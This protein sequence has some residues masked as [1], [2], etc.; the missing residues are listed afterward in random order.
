MTK[1]A[2]VTLLSEKAKIAASNKLNGAAKRREIW[3]RIYKADPQLLQKKEA[4][5]DKRVD[6]AR[7]AR[8]NAVPRKNKKQYIQQNR[9]PP[10]PPPN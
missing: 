2:R 9:K 5:I 8:E 6:Y 1:E 7:Q 10:P 4:R 3:Q